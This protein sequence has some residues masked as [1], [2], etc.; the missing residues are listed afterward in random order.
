MDTS[1]H[2]YRKA[3]EEE[4]DYDNVNLMSSD[5][6][7]AAN[8]IGTRSEVVVDTTAGD[9]G[10]FDPF[11]DSP[12][13]T[14]KVGVVVDNTA[15]DAGIFDPFRD[16]PDFT[17]KN[18]GVDSS[19]GSG[20]PYSATTPDTYFRSG[21]ETTTSGPRRSNIDEQDFDELMSSGD[22]MGAGGSGDVR[23]RGVAGADDDED[24][25]CDP[26]VYSV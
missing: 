25:R 21:G 17:T 9:A 15:G 6:D 24:G 11:S 26:I 10:I 2:R 12:V 14:K 7:T 20:K 16:S 8:F 23:M 1:K 18:V 4:P 13:F 19:P 3:R 5:S 22:D